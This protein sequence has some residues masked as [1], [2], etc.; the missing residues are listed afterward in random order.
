EVRLI[1]PRGT[2]LFA[3]LFRC[4][5]SATIGIGHFMR[6]WSLARALRDLGHDV[7]FAMRNTLN[8]V[9]EMLHDSDI[10]AVGMK[11]LPA[12]EEDPE[13]SLELPQ[14]KALARDQSV[15]CVLVD[16]YQASGAYLRSLG[17]AGDTIAVIDDMA[18][19]DLSAADWLLNP[20]PEADLL[21][22]RIGPG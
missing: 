11:G 22:Y 19:R 15:D 17:A 8:R 20:N 2:S 18:D 5:A 13:L 16:H 7:R 9:Q 12:V 3:F 21:P 1:W 4:D 6:C 10:A 14:L